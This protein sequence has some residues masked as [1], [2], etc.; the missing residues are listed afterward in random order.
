MTSAA[1]TRSAQLCCL[2]S[3]LLYIPSVKTSQQL[4]VNVRFLQ[5]VSRK[6]KHCLQAWKTDKIN[7]TLLTGMEN[8]QKTLF[9]GM[10]NRHKLRAP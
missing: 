2:R 1:S 8:R 5:S 9:T 4:L 7:T 6:I 3:P 10:E